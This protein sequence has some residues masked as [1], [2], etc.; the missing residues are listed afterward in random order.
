MVLPFAEE[1]FLVKNGSLNN[2]ENI[3]GFFERKANQ[4]PV[5]SEGT[6]GVALAFYICGNNQKAN[7]YHNQV[8]RMIGENGGIVYA[9][10]NAYEFS[11][12][13]SVAGTSWYIFFEMKINPFK[14][15]RKTRRSAGKFYKKYKMHI[16]QFRENL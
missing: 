8:K 16:R 1:Q 10:K 13:P 15:N 3:Q 2:T 6:E 9:T 14:P 12:F 11:T 4:A 5:W 7:F